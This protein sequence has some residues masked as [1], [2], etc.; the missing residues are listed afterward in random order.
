MTVLSDMTDELQ[1]DGLDKAGTHLYSF[2][3]RGNAKYAVWVNERYVA[4]ELTGTL[5]PDNTASNPEPQD[6]VVEAGAET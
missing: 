1:A 2:V 6:V 3:D 4:N 5:R